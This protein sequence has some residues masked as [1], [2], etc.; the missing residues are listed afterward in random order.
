LVVCWSIF[1]K[2][3]RAPR[4]WLGPARTGSALG[5]RRRH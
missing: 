3:D 2:A 4:S 5:Q 1:I